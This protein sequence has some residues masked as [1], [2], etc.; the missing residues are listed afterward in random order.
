MDYEVK[1]L[2]D[3]EIEVIDGDRGKNYPHQNELLDEGD[4]VFL[5]ANNVTSSGFKFDTIV[6]ITAEKDRILRNGKLR[7]NDIIITTRGTV[8]NVALYDETVPFDNVRINS[9]M[10][11]IR[12]KE[13]IDSR[14]LYDVF[15]SEAFLRQIRQ[16]QTGTAQPQ[17]PKSHFLKMTINLPP[18]RIQKKIASIIGDIDDKIACNNEINDNLEQQ[19]QALFKKMFPDVLEDTASDYFESI[20]SFS[21]GKKRPQSDGSVPVYG[22]NGILAYTSE[23]NAN[24]CVV[25]G[26]V[27][28][29]CGNTFLCQGNC[30]VSDNAIQAKSKNEDSQIFVYYLLKNASLPT[31]HIGTGQPLMTQGI[32]NAIP[33]SVPEQN[34]INN[35]IDNVSPMHKLIS[36]NL[37]ENSKLAKTR[38]ILLPQLM[39]GELDVSNL[40]I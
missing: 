24:N 7:R 15:R 31:R 14:Y 30:W 25:I 28:A 3:I 13:G 39:S 38:D 21:N 10:L 36:A 19:A 27:G 16:I 12:C 4:C 11:I 37:E 22:G 18:M 1:E 5:S 8:G 6:Y 29:Y 40:D 23:V 20:I 17:L 34:A 26:R 33:V 32:L 35:F 9:G 2:G